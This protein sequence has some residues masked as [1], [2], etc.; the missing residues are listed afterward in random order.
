MVDNLVLATTGVGGRNAALWSISGWKR[1]DEPFRGVANSAEFAMAGGS[2][3]RRKSPPT[4]ELVAAAPPSGAVDSGKNVDTVGFVV[5]LEPSA[6]DVADFAA[7]KCA[8][9][10]E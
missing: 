4:F 9:D 6:L 7:S 5:A 8:L 3:K 1:R 10:T 2:L